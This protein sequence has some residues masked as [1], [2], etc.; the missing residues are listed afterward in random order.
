[1]PCARIAATAPEVRP[2][3]IEKAWLAEF[4]NSLTACDSTTGRPWPP[5]SVGIG[6]LIQPPSE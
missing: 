6:R 3:Y 4:M 5:Y 2:G 1:V